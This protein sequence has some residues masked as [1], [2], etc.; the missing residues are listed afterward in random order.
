MNKNHRDSNGFSR[1]DF[2]KVGATGATALALTG[3]GA[4]KASAAE[5]MP[6]LPR[7]RYGRTGLQI[8]A[9]VGASISG[10]PGPPL[11]PR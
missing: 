3:M 8:S 1:R 10:M 9:L 2:I 7:R 11:G 6:Q 5:A 4:L